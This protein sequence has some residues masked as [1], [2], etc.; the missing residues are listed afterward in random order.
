VL[1][2]ALLAYGKGTTAKKPPS[3]YSTY[4]AGPKGYRALYEVLG[5]AGVPVQR[6][7][8]ALGTLDPSIR[9]LVV[10][11]YEDDPAA[12]PLDERDAAFL[13]RFVQDG[14][15]FVAID[16]YFVG[17]SDVTPGVGVSKPA[18]SNSAIPLARSPYTAGV[19]RVRGPIA[20]AFRFSEPRGVPLL[21]N[22][23]GM[24][25]VSYRFGRGEVV[26]ITAPDLFGNRQLRNP[27]NLRFAYNV[28][29]NHGDAAFDEF[30]HG[31]DDHLTMWAALPPPVHAAIWIV[32]AAVI[33][34]LI[35][36][37][38]PFAPPFN[39]QP[40][41]EPDSSAYLAALAELMRRSR[42]RP[43]DATVLREALLDFR[44][45]KEHV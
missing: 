6:F 1:L 30:V 43:S 7:E 26:A 13:R 23:R 2:L 41:Q 20:W 34:A 5:A 33:L 39:P 19:A 25:A 42:K 28:I 17:P 24:A 37:N 36:A 12:K 11:G 21:A 18:S 10:T 44:R 35:G 9:T 4:D 32:L 8:R 14:G 45:R 27:D 29:A 16:P 31:Y 38:L 22:E 40:P 3:V 15:R